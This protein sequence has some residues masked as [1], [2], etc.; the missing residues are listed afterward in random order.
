[1]ITWTEYNSMNESSALD[2]VRMY[3][4]AIITPKQYS[5]WNSLDKIVFPLIGVPNSSYIKQL[6]FWNS[7]HSKKIGF[8]LN[9]NE[10]IDVDGPFKLKQVLEKEGFRIIN[11]GI[12]FKYNAIC[13]EIDPSQYDQMLN[14]L[15]GN[16]A[17]SVQT[18]YLS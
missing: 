11:S 15:F 2:V 17:S 3:P 1:M 4:S 7:T 12:V 18:D 5:K 10:T 13:F 8:Q 16:Y 9:L 6:L 14:Y